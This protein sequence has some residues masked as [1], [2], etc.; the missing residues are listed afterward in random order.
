MGTRRKTT[1]RI[2]GDSESLVRWEYSL[3]YRRPRTTAIIIIAKVL[4]VF[5]H[6][7]DARQVRKQSVSEMLSIG[8][9]IR[10]IKTIKGYELYI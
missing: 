6:G 3:R 5:W 8:R 2:K 10:A 9:R 7:L 1:K 4:V